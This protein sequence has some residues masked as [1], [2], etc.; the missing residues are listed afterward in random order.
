MKSSTRTTVRTALGG[1]A[2]VFVLAVG[3]VAIGSDETDEPLEIGSAVAIEAPAPTP[4][5][6]AAADYGSDAFLDRLVDECQIGSTTACVD[7]YWESEVDSAYESYAYASTT[8]GERRSHPTATVSGEQMLLLVWAG[9]DSNE[10]SDF[11]AGYTALGA[12][13]SY[14]LVIEA[15]DDD[16]MIPTQDEYAAIFDARC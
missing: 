2:A 5:R 3:F 9:F 8:A 4:P 10:R 16:G 15:L 12:E 6:L 7:L 13:L 14:L 11:C 1:V